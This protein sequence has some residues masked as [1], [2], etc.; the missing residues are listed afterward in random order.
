MP[1]GQGVLAVRPA[2]ARGICP[3]R[4]A[5]ADNERTPSRAQ[6]F[7]SRRQDS[8]R[9]SAAWHSSAAHKSQR[10]EGRRR[11]PDLPP[12]ACDSPSYSLSVTGGVQAGHPQSTIL[13]TADHHRPFLLSAGRTRGRRRLAP[14]GTAW[15]GRHPA[16]RKCHGVY[17]PQPP[18][19]QRLSF[20]VVF[21]LY[22]RFAEHRGHPDV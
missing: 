7:Q 19:I 10:S 15:H 17:N 5:T 18:N 3:S 2:H 8:D 22:T 6:D 4:P 11:E 20:P 21:A 1:V 9:E 16:W 14:E 12:Q 13:P